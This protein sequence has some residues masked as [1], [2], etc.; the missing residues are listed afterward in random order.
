MLRYV[1]LED[2]FTFSLNI[3]IES[4]SPNINELQLQRKYQD[5]INFRIRYQ[6]APSPSPSAPSHLSDT[7]VRLLHN[8]KLVQKIKAKWPP[9]SEDDRITVQCEA[10]WV[11]EAVKFKWLLGDENISVNAV[12]N[13]IHHISFANEANT[14][15]TNN[16]KVTQVIKLPKQLQ[17]NNQEITCMILDINN[18]QV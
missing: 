16:L 15:N 11:T 2:D 1:K 5:P 18:V 17:L 9:V 13:T 4:K 10:Y 12:S 8:N 14:K 7:R 3:H 6:S